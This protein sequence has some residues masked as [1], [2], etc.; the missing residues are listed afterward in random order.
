VKR[1]RDGG[2]LTLLVRCAFCS[3]TFR[4]IG[5]CMAHEKTCPRR[6]REKKAAPMS[7]AEWRRA[8]LSDLTQGAFPGR[9]AERRATAPRFP[10]SAFPGGGS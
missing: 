9:Y 6:P 1:R 7:L 4:Q 10:S 5:P 3:R 8:H 2:G